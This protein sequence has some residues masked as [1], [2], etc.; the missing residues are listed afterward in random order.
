MARTVGPEAAPSRDR[1]SRQLAASKECSAGT[2]LKRCSKV[3]AS[4]APSDGTGSRAGS[5]LKRAP[6]L[7]RDAARRAKAAHANEPRPRAINSGR[8]PSGAGRDACVA[9]RGVRVSGS[10]SIVAGWA[11]DVRR[12]AEAPALPQP[13]R[14]H[15]PCATAEVAAEVECGQRRPIRPVAQEIVR[16]PPQRVARLHRIGRGRHRDGR[17]GRRCAGRDCRHRRGDRGGLPAADRSAGPRAGRQREGRAER[18]EGEHPECDACRQ[19]IEDRRALAHPDLAVAHVRHHRSEQLRAA[20]HPGHPGRHD[21]EAQRIAWQRPPGVPQAAGQW[22]AHDQDEH[23]RHGREGEQG[24]DRGADDVED[25]AR[26]T[27]PGRATHRLG[28]W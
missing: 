23:G 2:P 18:R 3:A 1:P 5:P 17:R 21:E 19:A 26:A 16:D 11:V 9:R 13:I 7:R 14:I 6:T 10:C 4:C 15:E 24:G 8:W 22:I 12:E 20:G 27:A 25:P 28:R